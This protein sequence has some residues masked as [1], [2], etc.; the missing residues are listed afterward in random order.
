MCLTGIVLPL[1]SSVF[2]GHG[3][4]RWSA[5][6]FVGWTVIGAFPLFMATIPS[7][8]VD[9]RHTATVLGIIM[10]A[11]EGVGGV[12]W[13]RPSPEMAADAHG[14]HRAAVD[15][16]LS[17]RSSRAYLRSVLRK[18]RRDDEWSIHA[19]KLRRSRKGYEMKT[20]WIA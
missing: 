17:C 4:R 7:E 11:G 12:S 5:L 15:H 10:G 14:L 19:A 2:P 1:A 3:V 20:A 8:T 9:S 18:R 16:V 6:F 13:H